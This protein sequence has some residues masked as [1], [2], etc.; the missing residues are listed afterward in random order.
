MTIAEL[1]TKYTFEIDDGP[2]NKVQDKVS[3]LVGFVGKLALAGTAAATAVFGMAKATADAGDQALA[4][5]QK[6]GIS[7]ENLTRLQFAAKLA[8]LD[9]GQ[10]NGGLRFLSKNAA[11]AAKGSGDTADAFKKLGVNVKDA[12]GGLRPNNEILLDVAAKMKSMPDGI[13]KTA[14]SM[15]IFGKSGADLI[16]LLNEGADGIQRMMNRSDELGATI[17]TELAQAS[18]EFNDSLDEMLSGMGGIQKMV[19]SKLIPVLTPM[20]QLITKWIIENKKIIAQKLEFV[21]EKLM[22][23]AKGVWV[24]FQGIYRVTSGLINIFGGLENVANGVIAAF[25]IISGSAILYGIGALALAVKGLAIYFTMANAAALAI[26]LAIGAI[27]AIVALLI[28]DLV[29]TFS[30]P[31]ADTIFRS[32]I[33]GVKDL[34]DSFVK[35]FD[36]MGFWGGMITNLLLTPLRALLGVFK[37]LSLVWDADFASKEGWANFASDAGGIVKNV[38]SGGTNIGDATGMNPTTARATTS[39]GE[40]NFAAN[41]QVVNNI[42]VGDNADPLQ[43]QKSVTFGTKDG[44]DKSL[45]GAER[46]FNTKGGY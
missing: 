2:L 43:I 42:T 33:N 17:S 44:L 32:L 1:V 6:L 7:V 22:M 5:S 16:P 11:E 10:F 46:S 13:N 36:S 21:F 39:K 29:T 26:P 38:F 41:N 20:I 19:G 25:M 3:N 14:L 35:F 28:E 9:V 34:W 4:T 23:F 24:I 27:I 31:E 30:D 15:K 18:D 12:N 8:N 45:R 40:R 37:A